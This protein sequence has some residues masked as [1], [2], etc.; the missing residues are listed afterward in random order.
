M[1]NVG[2]EEA[3]GLDFDMNYKMPTSIGDFS[4][5]N[6]FV[7]MGHYYES[8]YEEF[9]KQQVLGQFDRPRWRNNFTV[10]YSV[11][12]IDAR[13]VFRS[14]A[15]VE[16]RVRGRGKTV[17]PTQMDL[18]LTYDPSWAGQFQIGGINIFNVR[19]RFDD[20]FGAK[21]SGSLFQ[22]TETYYLTYRQ[23]F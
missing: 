17:S 3:N 23:D 8:F 13:M 18:S 14:L 12:Q 22:R 9:G 16:K 15:D 1:F 19:P 10:G 5:A 6:E 7:Y 2:T 4:F 21:V 20:T 11:G